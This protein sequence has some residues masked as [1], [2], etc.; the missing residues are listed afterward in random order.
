MPVKFF[1]GVGVGTHN[2]L[3]DFRTTGISPR[4][5]GVLNDVFVMQPING[6]TTYSPCVSLTKSFGVAR[7][8]AMNAGFHAPNPMVPAYVYEIHIP[9]KNAGMSIIDPVGFIASRNAN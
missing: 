2:Y 7:D 9:E 3:T 6:G 8:Y 5:T 4:T 1:K